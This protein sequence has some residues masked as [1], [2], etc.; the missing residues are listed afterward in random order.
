MI[1]NLIQYDNF[2]TNMLLSVDHKCKY[3]KK[4]DRIELRATLDGFISTL[5]EDYRN[6]W[7]QNRE[8]EEENDKLIKILYF[9]NIFPT[10]WLNIAY[11]VIELALNNDDQVASN[12]F[13]S[14]QAINSNYS[15]YVLIKNRPPK[16]INE[17]KK[18][19]KEE[20]QVP[21]YDEIKEKLNQILK[22]KL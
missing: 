14:L 2:I 10:E 7:N 18:F 15:W 19:M 8:L 20:G 22:L 5:A 1:D 9:I 16:D 4:D 11:E 21:N 6:L 13:A 17:L 3:I 12:T